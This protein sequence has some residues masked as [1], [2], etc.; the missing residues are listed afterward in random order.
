MAMWP[1]LGLSCT[2]RNQRWPTYIEICRGLETS[3][4]LSLNWILS[5]HLIGQTL[6]HPHFLGREA[7]GQE[8]R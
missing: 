8:V 4:R 5:S 7:E 6:F 2:V 3:L 1:C